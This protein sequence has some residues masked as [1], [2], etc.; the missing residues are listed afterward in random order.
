MQ[1]IL[2]VLWACFALSVLALLGIKSAQSVILSMCSATAKAR[3]AAFQ[4]AEQSEL[5]LADRYW[6]RN[7]LMPKRC[8]RGATRKLLSASASLFGI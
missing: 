1:P 2:I 7:P 4:P 8:R 3:M 6:S 5:E